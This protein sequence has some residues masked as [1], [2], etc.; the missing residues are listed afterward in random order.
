MLSRHVTTIAGDKVFLR[1]LTVEDA[2][3]YPDFLADVTAEDLRLRFF[4]PLRQVN[5]DLIDKLIHYDP[6]RAM[7]FVAIDDATGKLLGV[8]R[9]HDDA[10]GTSGEFAILLR[11]NLKGHGIG[12]LLMK[13][14]IVNAKAKG[15]RAVRGQVMTENSTMLQMCGELGF[16]SIADPLERGV[17]DVTLPLDEIPAEAVYFP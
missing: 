14:M 5:P 3:L 6:K 12:W 4:A 8:V 1:P 16:H 11:S 15:L 7:A 17:K 10:D 13:H 9:L 2:K